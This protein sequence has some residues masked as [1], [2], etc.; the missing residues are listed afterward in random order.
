MALNMRRRARNEAMNK[1]IMFKRLLNIGVGGGAAWA[2]GGF[3]A[4]KQKEYLKIAAEVKAGTKEDPRK[5]MGIDTEIVVG[6]IAS[7]G[8]VV[9]QGKSGTRFY[10]ELAESAGL[11]VLCFY[12]GKKGFDD[13]M[14]EGMAFPEA[15]A[16]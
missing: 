4:D 16:L 1:Q 12:A 7:I 9:M 14:A 8:G 5:L 3:M 2:M 6:G 10:G 11:G 13:K 15:P